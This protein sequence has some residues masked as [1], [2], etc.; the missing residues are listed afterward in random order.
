MEVVF[1]FNDLLLVAL[2]A[3]PDGPDIKGAVASMVIDKEEEEDV[4]LAASVA[5]AVKEY[6]PS[7]RVEEVTE[8]APLLSAVPE[9]K[10]VVPL[11][12]FTVLPASALPV[13]VGV[14]SSVVVAAVVNDDGAL[15]AVVSIVIV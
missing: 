3:L 4:L 14:E 13:I 15:G 11:Y 9:P 1:S 7:L 6:V 5:V 12:S 8:K 2:P 10:R